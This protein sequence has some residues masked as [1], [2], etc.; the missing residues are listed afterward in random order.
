MTQSQIDSYKWY[1][2][3]DFGNGL[4]T[5]PVGNEPLLS[6]I[7]SNMRKVDFKNKSVIDIGCRDGRLSILAE[8]LGASRVVAVDNDMSKA[9]KE[10]V[11][12]HFKSRME[13]LEANLIH[14]TPDQVKAPFDIVMMFGVL[15]HLRYPV[16]G[17]K[18]AVDLMKHN[19]LLLIETAA[20]ASEPHFLPIMFCPYEDMQPYERGSV[21]YFNSLGLETVMKSLGC[22]WSG[23]DILRDYT[24]TQSDHKVRRE[25]FVFQKTHETPKYLKEYWDGIHCCQSAQIE[26]SVRG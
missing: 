19:G 12:P 24:N 13:T 25:F 4:S 6:F 20:F 11:I 10:V 26:N 17:L 3:F 15:Y 22:I 1:H 16:Y 21:S 2:R 7:E 23:S 9:L 5:P 8:S 18:R 14:L